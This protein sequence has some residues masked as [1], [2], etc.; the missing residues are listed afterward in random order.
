MLINMC[1]VLKSNSK[2]VY[3]GE[4]SWRALPISFLATKFKSKTIHAD[5][6]S[7][8]ECS[9][10]CYSQNIHINC[11]STIMKLSVV[12]ALH[13]PASVLVLMLGKFQFGALANIT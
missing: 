6:I 10:C 4:Q 13:K 12:L 7:Y 3:Y 11:P 1:T 9:L 2:A 8:A 5:E